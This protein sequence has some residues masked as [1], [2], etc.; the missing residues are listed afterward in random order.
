M[1][2]TLLVEGMMCPHCEAHVKKAL[3][4]VDGV[5]LAIPSHKE[6]NVKI[7]LSKDVDVD[8]LKSTIVAQGYSVK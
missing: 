8:V 3:E 2:I 1:E 5:E 7:T 4:A 6:G